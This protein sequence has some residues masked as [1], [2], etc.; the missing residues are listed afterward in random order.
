M[1]TEAAVYEDQIEAWQDA[2]CREL[3]GSAE[4]EERTDKR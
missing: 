3:A 1:E 4:M 2:V